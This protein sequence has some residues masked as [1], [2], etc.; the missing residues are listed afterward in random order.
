MTMFDLVAYIEPYGTIKVTQQ[1]KR[2]DRGGRCKQGEVQKRRAKQNW[3]HNVLKFKPSYVL[4][5]YT[6]KSISITKL[7]SG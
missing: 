3:E 4:Q 5:M 1:E 6:Q 2:F 7:Q